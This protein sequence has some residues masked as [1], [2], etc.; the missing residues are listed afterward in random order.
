MRCFKPRRL[1]LVILLL[2]TARCGKAI[3]EAC[4]PIVAYDQAAQTRVADELKQLPPDS[5]LPRWI[6]DYGQLRAMARACAG[7]VQ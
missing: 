7:T 6:A 1:L 4:P 2:S 3:S 5:D